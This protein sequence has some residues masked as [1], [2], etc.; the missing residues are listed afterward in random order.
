MKTTLKIFAGL[1]LVLAVAVIA[2]RKENKTIS[3]IPGLMADGLSKAS[4]LDHEAP[5]KKAWFPVGSKPVT[6]ETSI[7]ITVPDGWSYMGY[8]TYGAFF[9]I[10]QPSETSITCVCNSK[11]ACKPF[12]ATGPWG[13]TG[14]CTGTCNNCTMTQSLAFMGKMIIPASGGFYAPKA[15]TRLIKDGEQVPAVFDALAKSDL[16]GQKLKEL[17][18]KAYAGR[19]VAAAIRNVDG[20]MEAPEGYCLIGASIMGRGLLVILPEDFVTEQLGQPYS[21]KASCDCTNGTGGCTL[22][23]KRIMGMGSMWCDGTCNGC[24][25]TMDS[26][27]RFTYNVSLFSASY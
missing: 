12:Y 25:L 11:G 13:G 5:G 14:G 16:F 22:S 26:K 2:C 9:Q 21:A 23:D 3:A 24:K 19:N 6:K 7:A 8:D 18:D 20:S 27:P 17:Y 4:S 15:P 10:H 1:S